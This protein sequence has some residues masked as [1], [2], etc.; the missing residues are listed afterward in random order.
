MKMIHVSSKL[1]SKNS[2]KNRQRHTQREVKNGMEVVKSK[3]NSVS[4]YKT[5]QIKRCG[6]FMN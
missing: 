4:V 5:E 1:Y 3:N 6:Q 2:K